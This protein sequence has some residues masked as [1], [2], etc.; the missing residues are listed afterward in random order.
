MYTLIYIL[1]TAKSRVYFHFRVPPLYRQDTMF[2]ICL[3]VIQHTMHIDVICINTVQNT[4]NLNLY[5]IY[6]K[7]K[8]PD[9]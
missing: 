5:T 3:A 1:T 4:K 9:N 2:A 6:I 7:T 8:P